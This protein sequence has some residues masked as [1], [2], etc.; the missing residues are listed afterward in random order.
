MFLFFHRRK[1]KES[2][3][4]LEKKLDVL[5]R[6]VRYLRRILMATKQEV[7]DAIAAEKAEVTQAL[8]DFGAQIQA[9]KDQL[10]QGTAITSADL[11][12]IENAVHEIFVPPVV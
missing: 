3:N 5:A 11:D 12:D 7:L 8:N 9:L 4:K 6:E 1:E 2:N 10:A